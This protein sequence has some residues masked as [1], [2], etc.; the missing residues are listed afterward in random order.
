MREVQEL[1]EGLV[2][3]LKLLTLTVTEGLMPK[4]FSWGSMNVDALLIRPRLINYWLTSIL[5]KMVP[6]TLMS[7]L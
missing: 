5:I 4:N 6:S 2:E 1:L 7:S 3:F